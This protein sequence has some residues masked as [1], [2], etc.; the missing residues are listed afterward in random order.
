MRNLLR[1]KTRTIQRRLY[2]ETN[3]LE[4]RFKMLCV[5]KGVLQSDKTKQIQIF[6]Y[7]FITDTI[8]V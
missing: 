8:Y 1:K 5:G 7:I 4:L 2:N 3:N 6:E